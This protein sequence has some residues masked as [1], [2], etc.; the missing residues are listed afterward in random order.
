MFSRTKIV[1]FGVEMV[2][3]PVVFVGVL[4]L[5][6]FYLYDYVIWGWNYV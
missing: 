5:F 4:D 3:D 2:A 6:G 1:E